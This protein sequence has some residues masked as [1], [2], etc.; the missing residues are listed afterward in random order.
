MWDHN[1]ILYNN[2]LTKRLQEDGVDV[3]ANSLHPGVINT[4]LTCNGGFFVFS[5]PNLKK[6][7][8]RLPVYEVGGAVD[9]RLSA[10]VGGVV[11]CRLPGAN[12]TEL[13]SVWASRRLSYS[14][15][16]KSTVVAA[17][18]KQIISVEQ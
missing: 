9:C 11:D 18:G 5:R 17:I 13:Y 3:T 2:T 15:F 8:C 4:N 10:K 14:R 12:E 7:N 16:S 6:L 1:T